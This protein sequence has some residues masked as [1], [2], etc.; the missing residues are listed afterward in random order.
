VIK[1]HELFVSIKDDEGLKL[2]EK[3]TLRNLGICHGRIAGCF[4]RPF[5]EFFG[6]MKINGYKDADEGP[7]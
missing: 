6:F 3:V 2:L 4:T 7:M 1:K 5:R